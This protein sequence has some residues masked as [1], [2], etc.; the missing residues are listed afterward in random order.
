MGVRIP[1]APR[2]QA[3][4]ARPIRQRGPTPRAAD[5]APFDPTQ[6]ALRVW[7]SGDD[8]RASLLAGDYFTS[9]GLVLP[10]DVGP[11][12]LRFHSSLKLGEG[13][14][15]PGIVWLLR[16]LHSDRP[17]AISRVFLAEDGRAFAQRTL[18]RSFNTAVKLSDDSDVSAGLF[19]TSGVEAGIA[20]MMMGLRPVWSVISQLESFPILPGIE[21]LTVLADDSNAESVAAVAGRWHET[22]AEVNILAAARPP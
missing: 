2:R 1:L 13:D 9:C 8:A 10:E 15:A 6:L 20:A 18:G 19:I 12:V 5:A 11:D 4:A 14:R 22:G 16:D 7:H 17:V 3:A 21:A